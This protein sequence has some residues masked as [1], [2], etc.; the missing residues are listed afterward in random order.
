MFQSFIEEEISIALLF[1]TSVSSIQIFEIDDEGTRCMAKAELVKRQADSQET[2]RALTSTYLCDVNVTTGTDPV[3]SK[4][5]RIF[6]SSYE[7]SEAAKLLS[8][9][10]GFDVVPALEKQK[11]FPTVAFAMPLAPSIRCKGRLYTFLPLP[12]STGFPCHVH[13]LFALT[14]DRQ[15]LRNGEE[16]GLVKGVD[17]YVVPPM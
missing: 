3:V 11:L 1:L 10:L 15:H 9:R 5:W 16:T 13:A 14:P 4:S 6:S 8:V 7:R 2:G 17:R 12:L